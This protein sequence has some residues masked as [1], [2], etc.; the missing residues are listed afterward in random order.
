MTNGGQ[1]LDCTGPT[2]RSAAAEGWVRAI[3][4]RASKPEDDEGRGGWKASLAHDR[5]PSWQIATP[6]FAP[7]QSRGDGVEAFVA[8]HVDVHAVGAEEGREGV[9][10]DVE[11]ARIGTEGWHDEAQ[12]VADETGAADGVAQ[13]RKARAGVEVACDLMRHA[14]RGGDVAEGDAFDGQVIAD[15]AA[16]LG[17]GCAVVVAGEPDPVAVVLQNGQGFAVFVRHAVEG[18]F[19]VE[20]VAE[21]DDGRGGRDVERFGQAGQRFAGVVG[22]QHLPAAG[23]G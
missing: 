16:E 5:L 4:A 7:E 19:V 10:E 17:G 13:S 15:D 11:A 23:E 6:L 21:R 20:A 12:A 18:C 9:V 8:H 3:S 22:W 2:L 14:A 1:P